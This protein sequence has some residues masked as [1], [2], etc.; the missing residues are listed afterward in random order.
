MKDLKFRKNAAI[1]RTQTRVA[2]LPMLVFASLSLL[3]LQARASQFQEVTTTAGLTNEQAY[4]GAVAWGDYDN[5][6]NLDFH[7]AI[8]FTTTHSNA[9]YHNNGNGTFTRKTAAQVGPIASDAH[10]SWGC[11]W[12]DFN[13]DG[14]PDMLAVNGGFS[15]ARNDLYMN[16]GDGTFRNASVGNLTGLS[17][18]QAC[19]APADY[20]GDGL[21]D[22]YLPQGSSFSGPFYTRL[23]HA[24][25]SGS[26]TPI[27]F[28]PTTGFANDGAWGD[29]NRDGKPDLFVCNWTSGGGLWRNDG[30]GHFTQINNGLPSAGLIAHAAWGDYDNDSNLD[31]AISTDG[32]TRVYRNNGKGGF[33]LVTNF[34]AAVYCVP[35]WAD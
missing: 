13:N 29:Y 1:R 24:T 12:V 26:F 8:G 6:G 27:D 14:Y 21:V 16:N 31:I 23:Y 10:D 9:L 4:C 28:G 11:A 17:A 35:A 20:D 7:I 32:G 15:P 34:A 18:V 30:G 33:V 22:V 3:C 25:P 19:A 5:D 2:D